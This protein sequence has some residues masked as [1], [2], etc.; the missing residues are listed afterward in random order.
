MSGAFVTTDERELGRSGPITL[1]SV[2]I[3]VAYTR[4]GD[5]RRSST[6]KVRV[7]G[8]FDFSTKAG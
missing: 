1:V 7:V 2:K 8:I 5:L 3:S 4:E 6:I